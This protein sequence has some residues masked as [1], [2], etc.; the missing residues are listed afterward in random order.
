MDNPVILIAILIIAAMVMI[1][2]EILTP[3]FGIMAVLAVVAIVGAI[4]V[5]FNIS[6]VAGAIA[7]IIVLLVIP[8]YTIILV[9]RLP[10]SRIGGRLFLK[11]SQD[12]SGDVGPDVNLSDLVG[13]SGVA[14][15]L[16]RP[17]GTVIIDGRRLTA[18]AESGHIEKDAAVM[19]AR[20]E[21]NELIVRQAGRQ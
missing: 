10:K 11:Q 17:S 13:K 4:F 20:V 18:R 7:T 16:L 1:F 21:G 6:P 14:Q 19:V 12:L 5:G 15:T 2:L 9:K 8:A 3:T